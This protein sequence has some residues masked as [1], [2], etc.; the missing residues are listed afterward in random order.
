M[1]F[2]S[3]HVYDAPVFESECISDDEFET[4]MTIRYVISH[5]V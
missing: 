3:T 5:H 4:G 2:A 1:D